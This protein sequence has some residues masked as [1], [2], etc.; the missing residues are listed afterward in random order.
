MRA[1][2]ALF[3]EVIKTKLAGRRG[4]LVRTLARGGAGGASVIKADTLINLP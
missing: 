1:D 2:V 3:P 4:G